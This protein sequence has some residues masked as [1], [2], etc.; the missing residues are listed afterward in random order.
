MAHE[1]EVARL[2]HAG[3]DGAD[4]D[5]VHVLPAHR[6]ERVLGHVLLARPRSAPA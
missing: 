4:A 1:A 5:L 6:E 3:V 2:D